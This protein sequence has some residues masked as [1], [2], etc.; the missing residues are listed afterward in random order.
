MS[1]M[2]PKQKIATSDDIFEEKT[3]IQNALQSVY[4]QE[5]AMKVNHRLKK[6]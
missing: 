3:D 2:R 5:L 4:W 6:L 1:I